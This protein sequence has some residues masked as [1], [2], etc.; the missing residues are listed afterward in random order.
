VRVLHI[1]SYMNRAGQETFIMNVY[2]NIDRSQVQFDFVVQSQ[3][4][5]DYDSEIYQL[6]G[7]IYRLPSIKQNILLRFFLLRKLVKKN[8]Y[9]IVHRHTDKSL[10]WVD[11]LAAKFG[12]AAVRIAHSHSSSSQYKTLHKLC[13]PFMNG[14]STHKFACSK[15]A[16]RWL[17][18]DKVVQSGRV[19]VIHNAIDVGMFQYNAE[20]RRQ[21]RQF[22]DLKDSFV[23]GHVGRFFHV[24]NHG[25]LIDVFYEIYCQNPKAKLMLVGDGELK[26]QIKSKVSKLGLEKAVLF[27]GVRNDVYALMQAMDV[28]ALPSLFEGLPLVCIEAQVALLPCIISDT[29]SEEVRITK[30]V[31]FQSLLELPSK[32]AQTILT[33]IENYDRDKLLNDTAVKNS[34]YNVKTVAKSLQDF[35]TFK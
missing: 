28:F 26:E 34:P 20:T 9:K 27:L 12:G 13:R 10:E 4:P 3:N 14:F 31:C 11:L 19:T 5:N 17:Y 18:G 22:L 35:Y 32:W 25:F 7:R 24:K 6:G 29:I 21:Y 30:N 16:A 2:K 23:I 15:Q 1:V 33:L 8:G